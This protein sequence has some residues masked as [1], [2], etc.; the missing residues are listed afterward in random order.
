MVHRGGSKGKEKAT[1]HTISRALP[2]SGQLAEWQRELSEG[3]DRA[4]ALV[5]AALLDLYLEKMI[6][7]RLIKLTEKEHA[8]LFTETRAI[9]GTLSARTEI[10]Y[11]LGIIGPTIRGDLTRVRRIRN[12]FAHAALPLDF[13]NPL[14]Q[15]E[16]EALSIPN[17]TGSR[18]R[19]CG[20][21]IYL[22]HAISRYMVEH[23]EG[24]VAGIEA[25][26]SEHG[27][28]DTD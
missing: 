1:I 3:S 27:S 10:A 21:V 13:E 15:K 9:L 23:W 20:T 5:G 18:D 28:K 19:Y 2:Q 4:C 25:R 11:A 8:S 16:T 22:A 26:M 14:I 17:I 24:I 12:A 7:T 6:A